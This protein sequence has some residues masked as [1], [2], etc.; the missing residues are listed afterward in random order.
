MPHRL[1][2]AICNEVFEN[3]PFAGACRAIRQAG[4]TGVEIAP[5]TLVEDPA[6]LNSTFEQALA[7]DT[8]VL[9]DVKTE[10]NCPTPV[11][12]FTAGARAWSYHE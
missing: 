10:K 3:R 11:Y 12:D 2:H 1:R 8:T 9:I 7:A 4:Y 6:T 5:F